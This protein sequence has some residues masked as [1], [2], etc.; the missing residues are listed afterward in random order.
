MYTVLVQDYGLSHEGGYSITFLKIPGAVSSPG[1]Q[2]GGQIA[3]GQTLSGT[4][5]KASDLDAFQF[6][7][8]AGDRVI[9]N[10]VKTSGDLNTYMDLYSPAPGSVK[11]AS[12]WYDQLDHVLLETGMYTVLVQ[13]N[14][15]SHEGGYSISLIK[16]PSDLRPGIYDP[17]PL[18]GSSVYSLNNSFSWDPVAGATGYD[19]YFGENIIAPL[20]KIGNNLASNSMPFPQMEWGKIYYWHVIAHTS[21]GAIAGPYWW[22]ST[23]ESQGFI[24]VPPSHWA[25]EAIYKIYNA[26]ITKG[27]SADPLMYCPD[28]VVSKAAMAVFLLRSLHGG[29]Y[30]PPPATGIFTDVDVNEWYAPWVEQLYKEGITKGCSA[31]PLMYC[32]DRDVSK[33][34][35]AL[36]LL[37][38]KYGSSYTPPAATG[39]FAD[40]DLSHWGADWIEKLYNDGITKGCSADPLMYCPDRAV[41]RAAM[42]LFLVRTFGL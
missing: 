36:F 27:C 33:A 42:A 4:I 29:D 35:M 25:Y 41:S 14:G 6:Y 7:G 8:N 17:Y 39:I 19:L 15:L 18:N 20:I 31:S 40:V 21:G 26:G 32:P 13:D 9:I 30:T 1:D 2:D 37:R 28:K 3:S 10:A 34:S 24:D 11:E 12:P 23:K 5:N 22:F 38:V 16:I